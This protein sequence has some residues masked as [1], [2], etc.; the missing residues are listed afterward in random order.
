[1]AQLEHEFDIC[2]SVVS[3]MSKRKQ[4]ELKF[5]SKPDQ[6]K[7]TEKAVDFLVCGKLGSYAI[8]HTLIESHPNRMRDDAQFVKLLKPLEEKLTGKLPRLGCYY[9]TVNFG[10]VKGVKRE[11]E[12]RDAIESWIYAKASTLQIDL[13]QKNYISEIPKGVPFKVSL[14]RWST[15]DGRFFIARFAPEDLKILRRKRIKFALENKCPKLHDAKKNDSKIRSVLIL[16][17]NDI[18]LSNYPDIGKALVEAISEF[19]YHKPDEIYLVE[20]G[21]IWILKD[22]GTVFPHVQQPGPYVRK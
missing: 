12:V 8:E 18:A 13:P 9:L 4:E 11:Q 16:E 20:H 6:I 1:L 21:F 15:S 5:V 17:S 2:R 10:A 19:A 14:H 7:R 22:G 3:V